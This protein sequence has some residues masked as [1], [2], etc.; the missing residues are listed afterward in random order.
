MKVNFEN[1]VPSSWSKA[2]EKKEELLSY[3]R[4]THLDWSTNKLKSLRDEF[5]DY[6]L[7]GVVEQLSNFF[8]LFWL[9]NG[10]KETYNFLYYLNQLRLAWFQDTMNDGKPVTLTLVDR[11]IHVTGKFKNYR[12][13]SS[14]V[15]EGIQ[16][17]LLMRD[18]V[19]LEY[20]AQIPVSFTEQANQEDMIVEITMAF[21][22][23]IAKSNESPKEAQATFYHLREQLNWETYNQYVAKEGFNQEWVW[24]IIFQDRK[25]YT[26]FISLP[27]INIY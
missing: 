4:T 24:K 17:A 1:H 2:P 11:Q 12:I 18:K 21:Y 22:Q 5:P 13:G 26:E 3:Y 15:S 8:G 25:E 9:Y 19:A 14:D 27:V 10:Q 20:Y 7:S 23:L 6:S 16:I